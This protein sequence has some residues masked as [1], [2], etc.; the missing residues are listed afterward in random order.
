[1]K[2]AYDRH[3]DA[4]IIALRDERVAE[5]DEVRP[6]L[7]VDLGSGGGVVRLEVLRASRAA[8]NTREIQFAVA[9]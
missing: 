7:I 9:D 5:C 3:A 1:M 2:V 8:H 6:S 4:L